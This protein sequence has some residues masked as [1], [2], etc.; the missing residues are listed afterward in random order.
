MT[1]SEL[2][3]KLTSTWS[4][5]IS[6]DHLSRLGLSIGQSHRVYL[7]TLDSTVTSKFTTLLATALNTLSELCCHFRTDYP[8]GKMS[9]FIKEILEISHPLV[10]LS[11]VETFRCIR[12]VCE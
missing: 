5:G 12:Q 4:Q 7:S 9:S 11:P 2:E 1:E 8:E 10:H 3:K 6:P